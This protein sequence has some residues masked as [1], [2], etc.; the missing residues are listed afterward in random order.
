MKKDIFPNNNYLYYFRYDHMINVLKRVLDEKPDKVIGKLPGY[1]K[2]TVKKP[3]Y[4]FNDVKLLILILSA[5]NMCWQDNF[6]YEKSPK[7]ICPFS[8]TVLT[9]YLSYETNAS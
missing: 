7:P 5:Q 6:S 2:S 9:K 4:D 8:V 1:H 3:E